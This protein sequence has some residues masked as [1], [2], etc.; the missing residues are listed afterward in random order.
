MLFRS[1]PN[2]L[3]ITGNAGA[4]A[5]TGTAFIDSLNGGGGADIYVVTTTAQHSAAE[6]ADS[7]ASGVDELRFASS[8]AGEVLTVFAADTG[9]E[10]VTI[11]TGTAAAA[12]VTA[13]TALSINASA[14]PNGLTIT[15]NNGV[16]TLT[17]TAFADTITGGGG[18]DAM[19]GGDSGD[20][21]VIASSADHSAAEIADS[22]ASGVDE[23]RFASST[24]G[25]TLTVFAADTGLEKVTIGTGTAAAPVVTATTA[26][27]VNASAAPNGLTITGN[28]GANAITG[29][30]F[31]DSLNGGGGADIYVVT[32][33]AQIGRAHV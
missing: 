23:L 14:A 28:A 8:T 5:I 3:T 27:N 10:A 29:T 19:N 7:G 22:G 32:T 17:G 30:A 12:V 26:L 31:I 16:N 21:Y 4:N 9:L 2:G 18:L 13:T 25:Q 33:T 24:A 15:G 20:L 6:I 1:A 11:G